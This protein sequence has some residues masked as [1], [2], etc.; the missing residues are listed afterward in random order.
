MSL[1]NT[2]Q[3]IREYSSIQNLSRFFWFLDPCWC[4]FS[5]VQPTHQVRELGR[6]WQHNFCVDFDVCFGSLSWW[7]VLI[8]YLLIFGWID[9]VIFEQEVQDLQQ[10]ICPQVTLKIQWYIKLYTWD[11]FYPCVQTHLGHISKKNLLFW[12][13]VLTPAQW[14]TAAHSPQ[15]IG[16]IRAVPC[17]S[18]THLKLIIPR[19]TAIADF[20]QRWRQ[21][22]IAAFLA[23]LRL[24]NLCPDS[25]NGD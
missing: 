21:R 2:W 5:A 13:P 25:G 19:T 24:L 18:T 16:F 23:E 12:M 4:F 7:K 11:N 10:K 20:K 22:G 17:R 8:F 9:N 14:L 1:E 3:D 15:N 6:S